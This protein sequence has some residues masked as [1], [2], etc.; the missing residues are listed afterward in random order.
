MKGESMNIGI[1]FD[2]VLTD[3]VGTAVYQMK[4]EEWKKGK[5]VWK[6]HRDCKSIN[7]W[8]CGFGITKGQ[9]DKWFKSL[10]S[11]FWADLPMLCTQEDIVAINS[12]SRWHSI[13]A[14]TDTPHPDA[15]HQRNL[16]LFNNGIEDLSVIPIRDKVSIIDELGITA[17]LEDSPEQLVSISCGSGCNLYHPIYPYNIRQGGEGVTSI[18]DYLTRIGVYNV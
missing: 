14:L 15:I 3:F 4:F 6:S 8:Q 18:V 13:F 1:D 2:G 11:T 12:V 5:L 16:W 10:P 17:M 7:L 9:Y